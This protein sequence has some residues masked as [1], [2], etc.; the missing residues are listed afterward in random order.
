[1]SEE[2]KRLLSLWEK[3]LL[4]LAALIIL[5]F[6]LDRMGV[7]LTKVTEDTEIIDPYQGQ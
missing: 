3:V 7:N 6:L 4:V 1:M 5:Y 2:K